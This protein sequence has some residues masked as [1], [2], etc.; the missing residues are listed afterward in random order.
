M[1]T[2]RALAGVNTLVWC[3]LL[4]L[5]AVVLY[6]QPIGYAPNPGQIAYYLGA[7]ILMACAVAVTY[8]FSR[9]ARSLDILLAIQG[10]ALLLVVPYILG[11]T[12][13]V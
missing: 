3:G 5:G 10:V 11:Y 8:F 12:G 6:E 9:S 7:P 13:G 4:V 2:M 1:K